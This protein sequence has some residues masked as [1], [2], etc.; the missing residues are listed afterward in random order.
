MAA[1]VE[2]TITADELWRMP[3]D[4]LRHE[5]VKGQL[6]TMPLNGVLHGVVA[7]NIAFSLSIA[8]E[9]GDLGAT[10]ATG[11]GFKIASAPDTVRAPDAAF[12]ARERLEQVGITEEFWPGAPD[13]AVE[14]LDLDDTYAEVQEKIVGWLDAGTRLVIVADPFKHLITVYHSLSDIR[15]LTAQDIL[16]GGDVVPGW[17]LPVAAIFKTA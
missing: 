12:V 3:D 8:V 2:R 17:R 1:V 9:D 6:R 10:V 14:V 11:T 5:L 16:D 4:G 15:V 7:M 13:V